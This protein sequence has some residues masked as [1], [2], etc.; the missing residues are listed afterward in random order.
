MENLNKEIDNSQKFENRI[1]S[2][3]GGFLFGA[4]FFPLFIYH[5]YIFLFVFIFDGI[6]NSKIFEVFFIGVIIFIPIAFL[7]S[8]IMDY[9]DFKK[10]NNR[11]KNNGR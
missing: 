7:I 8:A 9:I 6:L 4:I 2:F 1:F 5:I 10:L 11:R 3:L